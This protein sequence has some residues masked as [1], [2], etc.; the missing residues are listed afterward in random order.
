MRGCRLFLISARLVVAWSIRSKRRAWSASRFAANKSL[1][2]V[3]SPPVWTIKRSLRYWS[4]SVTKRAIFFPLSKIIASW[5]SAAVASW[6]R[7]AATYWSSE[8]RLMEPVISSAIVVVNS[9]PAVRLRAWSKMDKASRIPPSA[10][11]AMI[12]TA[13]AS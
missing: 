1:A 4:K 8:A 6:A 2:W 7:M 10:R 13:S 11:R 3:F 5:S 12:W 9:L